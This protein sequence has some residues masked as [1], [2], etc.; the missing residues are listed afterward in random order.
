VRFTNLRN[1]YGSQEE[2]AIIDLDSYEEF[3][4]EQLLKKKFLTMDEA[5]QNYLVWLEERNEKEKAELDLSHPPEEDEEEVE[6]EN[7]VLDL[8]FTSE[9][10]MTR[11]QADEL[12]KD[13]N[14]SFGRHSEEKELMISSI[15]D[16]GGNV[17][18]NWKKLSFEEKENFLSS[19]EKF[20]G[21][22]PQTFERQLEEFDKAAANYSDSMY[23]V[24][25]EP[26]LKDIADKMSDGGDKIILKAGSAMGKTEEVM[27]LEAFKK[28]SIDMI[29]K[30]TGISPE[31]LRSEWT[32]K[33]PKD[34]EKIKRIP[35]MRYKK[36]LGS[37]DLNVIDGETYD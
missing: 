9:S 3:L 35:S 34:Q 23:Q 36:D 5:K 27:S 2:G 16:F 28:H 11:S 10:L 17:L 6:E 1:L 37:G 29:A 19:H 20:K 15:G 12:E 32:V 13:F 26:N 4:K 30:N 24:V 22:T 7:P 14:E 8:A 18:D 25:N 33:A 31:E 21:Y